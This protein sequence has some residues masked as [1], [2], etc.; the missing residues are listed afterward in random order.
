MKQIQLQPSAQYTKLKLARDAAR[1]RFR[2][3]END[4]EQE[5]LWDAYIDA[6]RALNATPE[7]QYLAEMQALERQSIDG[8]LTNEARRRG[9]MTSMLSLDDD[10]RLASTVIPERA[11][12]KAAI[13]VLADMRQ[14]TAAQVANA[15][16][17]MAAKIEA[18]GIV[19]YRGTHPLCS[20]GDWL[21]DECVDGRLMHS[22]IKE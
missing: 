6:V 1:D 12:G 15:L 16:Q 20:D 11:I 8:L 9:R 5:Q 22:T 4:D 21:V 10:G 18:D 3:T 17:A 14:L 2:A 19:V 13:T 7:A